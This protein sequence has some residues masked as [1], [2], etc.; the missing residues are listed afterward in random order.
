[1]KRGWEKR[2][3]ERGGDVEKQMRLNEKGGLY[4]RRKRG[5]V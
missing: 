3:R 5:K 4:T 2:E 1:M